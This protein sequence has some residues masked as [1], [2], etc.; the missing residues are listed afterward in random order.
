MT[1]VG[2]HISR[3]FTP[4]CQIS[5]RKVLIFNHKTYSIAMGTNHH[6]AAILKLGPTWPQGVLSEIFFGV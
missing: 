1:N 5:Y 6:L 2:Y 3:I 4:W